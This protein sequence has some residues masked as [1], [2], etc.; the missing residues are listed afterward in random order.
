MH[1]NKDNK[2]YLDFWAE[3]RKRLLEKNRNGMRPIDVGPVVMGWRVS[4]SKAGDDVYQALIY[5][6]GAFIL[7]SL[8]R[9]F[10]TRKY[11]DAPF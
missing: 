2:P 10:W 4:S 7:H 8:D 6:K 9:L 1:T 11:Q 3:Q 5:S